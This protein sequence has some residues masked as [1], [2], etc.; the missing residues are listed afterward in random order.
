M[1]IKRTVDRE[2][3]SK[4]VGWKTEWDSGFQG[5]DRD[6]SILKL[7]ATARCA[8][9]APL[10]SSLAKQKTA[11]L[12]LL[13]LLPAADVAGVCLTNTMFTLQFN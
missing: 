8:R 7:F 3:E 2:R 6:R 10:Y 5:G 13:L 1:T 11:L 9:L 4:R 12:L